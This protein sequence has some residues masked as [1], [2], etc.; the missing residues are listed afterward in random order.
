VALNSR[1]LL[2]AR[3]TITNTSANA[4]DIGAANV[5][6]GNGYSL[7]AGATVQLQLNPGDQVYAVRSG[8]SDAQLSVL[9]S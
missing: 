2:G 9:L 8:T 4:A 1:S 5:A 6:A 3:M 7:P